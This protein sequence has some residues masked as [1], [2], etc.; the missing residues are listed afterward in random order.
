MVELRVFAGLT[1]DETAMA[2]AVNEKT[3]RRDWLLAR[4]WLRRE[5]GGAPA[6]D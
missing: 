4:A 3:V 6:E 2:L 5:I 1:L